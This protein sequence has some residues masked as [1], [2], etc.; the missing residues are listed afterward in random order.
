MTKISTGMGK[1]KWMKMAS[2]AVGGPAA[3]STL[4]GTLGLAVLAA[5]GSV[6]TEAMVTEVEQRD[7]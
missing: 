7:L 1:P 5:K 6:V 4:A 3:G 2:V